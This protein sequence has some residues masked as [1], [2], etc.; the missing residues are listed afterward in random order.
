MRIAHLGLPLIA[1]MS[2]GACVG[3]DV[4]G[5]LIAASPEILRQARIGG[6]TLS[7]N[8]VPT[9]DNHAGMN[10]DDLR[11]EL[12]RCARGTHSLALRL[13]IED[14][15]RRDMTVIA[16]FVDPARNDQIVG[17]Y[18]MRP[19][20]RVFDP[21]RNLLDD[22]EMTIA[23]EIGYAICNTAFNTSASAPARQD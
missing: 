22:R 14:V 12:A 4:N 9:A 10:T 15:F 21:A 11:R 5:P 8:G 16:E 18:F 23:E 3:V 7:S 17:R 1:A 19:R 13:D 20:E 6:I 2:L